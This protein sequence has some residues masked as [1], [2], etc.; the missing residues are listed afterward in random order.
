MNTIRIRSLVLA[1]L[2]AL[3]A[4][5]LFFGCK[6]P[7]AQETYISITDP[8]ATENGVQPAATTAPATKAAVRESEQP[9]T[10]TETSPLLPVLSITTKRQDKHALDFAEKPVVPYIADEAAAKLFDLR[11][12]PAPYYEACFVTLTD[13]EG[14]A[15]PE[16]ASADIRVRGNWTT[17]YD[18]KPLRIKFAEKQTMLGLNGGAS[19]KNWVL[20]AEYKDPSYLRN[21]TALAFSRELLAPHGFYAAD[22][23]L[24]EVEINDTYWGVYLLTEQ[25]EVNK[26][27]IAIAKPDPEEPSVR[28]GYLLEYDG[29]AGHEDELHQ[30]TVSYAD[31][32]PLTPYD[33]NGGSDTVVYPL[34]K[35]WYDTKK[36]VGFSIKSDILTQAQHDFIA[37]YT[38]NVYRILYAAAYEKQA[39]RFNEE[40][41]AVEKADITPQAAVEAVIDVQSLADMYV[42]SEL[43][44]DADLN[45]SSFFMDVD[46]SAEGSGKL[47][48]EAPWDFDSAMGLKDRCADGKGFY[49]AN[50]VPDLDNENFT[51]NPWLA[52]LAYEDWFQERVRDTW[53][54]A[55]DDGVF[56]RVIASIGEDSERCADAFAR[57]VKRWEKKSNPLLKDESAGVTQ[58]EAAEQLASWLRTRVDF[59]NGYWY[60]VPQETTEPATEEP[61]EE[62][63]ETAV[64]T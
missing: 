8:P 57:D 41:T 26:H 18:K 7:D 60:Q 46:L 48:F 20:L 11:N 58:Q 9:T 47:R 28:T 12:P 32:A 27:R 49:A 10:E 4:C 23:Q 52:V 38:D 51:I 42:L 61:T 37:S 56:D 45:W 50:A 62:P 34:R 21:K 33:G 30:F 54:R 2:T 53:S 15:L 19:M 6:A 63:S 3:L 64:N 44:C 59:L 43:L 39:Y 36:N 14:N 55:Y 17:Y 5:P 35:C 22:A 29:Y 13:T 24:V 31:N 1:G 25:Q 40:L 16:Q